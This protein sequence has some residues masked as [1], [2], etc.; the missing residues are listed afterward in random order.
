M[1]VYVFDWKALREYLIADENDEKSDNDFGKNVIPTMLAAGERM[2]AFS[3]GGY[4]RDVGTLDSL[5]QANMDLLDPARPIEQNAPDGFRIYS[6]NDGH[7]STVITADADVLNSYAAEGCVIAGS[8]EG[9][10][11][12]VGTKIGRG[13]VVRDSVLMPGA[14]IKPGAEVYKAIIGEGTVIGEDAKVGLPDA[15]KLTVI[16][17]REKIEPGAEIL[18]GT[19]M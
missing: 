4:W 11:V 1:G 2:F 17:H 5:W 19:V 12:S 3:F 14:V 13:A 7:P 9:S 10:I 15:G 18:P 6:R 8:V 16:G